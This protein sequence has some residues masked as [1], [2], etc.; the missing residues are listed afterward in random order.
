M[1]AKA[2]ED[3]KMDQEAGDYEFLG[4]HELVKNKSY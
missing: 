1:K 3:I 2:Q 4:N